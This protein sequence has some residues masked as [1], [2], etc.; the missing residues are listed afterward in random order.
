MSS[1]S[2]CLRTTDRG[3]VFR[4]DFVNKKHPGAFAEV[5]CFCSFILLC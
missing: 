1:I 2:R 3:A 4:F 5:L